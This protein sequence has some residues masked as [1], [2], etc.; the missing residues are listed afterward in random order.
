MHRVFPSLSVHASFMEMLL[1]CAKY[2]LSKR[3]LAVVHRIKMI[4]PYFNLIRVEQLQIRMETRR[5][6][7]MKHEIVVHERL[8]IF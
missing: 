3:H 6:F 1:L 4:L 8:H 2:I 7:P 5:K